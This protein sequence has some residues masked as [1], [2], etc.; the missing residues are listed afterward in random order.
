MSIADSLSISVFGLGTVF[1]VLIALSCLVM[2]Q[3]AI[4]R[5]ISGAKETK[6]A[7]GRQEPEKPVNTVCQDMG[8]SS[9]ELKLFGVDEKTAAMI[10]AIV[11]DQ[12]EI[13]LSE[14]QFKTISA[15]D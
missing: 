8:P 6:A 3:S 7:P 10:M 15:L 4:F 1:V 11:S 13:P 12:S 5:N 2:A 14:L 9:G